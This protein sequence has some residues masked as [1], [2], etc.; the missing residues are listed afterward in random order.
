MDLI[1]NVTLY[2]NT[3]ENTVFS[4]AHGNS[5]TDHIL[6]QNVDLNNIRKSELILVFYLAI[7]EKNKQQ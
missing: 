4:E 7:R 2:P 5:K 6:S 3:V 1:D